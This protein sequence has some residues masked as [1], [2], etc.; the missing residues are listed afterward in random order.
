MYQD[1]AAITKARD[2][3]KFSVFFQKRHLFYMVFR[4]RVGEMR[5]E[6]EGYCGKSQT[7]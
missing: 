1:P 2:S 3:L 7:T 6:V 5:L 4:V